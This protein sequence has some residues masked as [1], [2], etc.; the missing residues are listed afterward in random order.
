M[1]SNTLGLLAANSN[2][3]CIWCKCNK[4]L[5][6]DTNK[7][8]SMTNV[9]QGARSFDDMRK[10]LKEN[11]PDKKCGY[12]LM[13]LIT[14][15]VPWHHYL[16]DMLHLF[17]RISDKLLNNL[18]DDIVVHDCIISINSNNTSTY[19]SLKRLEEFIN[20]D[21]KIKF[22]FEINDKNKLEMRS[23]DGHQKHKIFSK[24]DIE[25]I[26][27]GY[28]KASTIDKIWKDF[29]SIYNSI[30]SKTVN[31]EQVKMETKEWLKL[32]CTVYQQSTI[33]PYMHA[34]VYHLHEFINLYKDI[35][36][37]TLEGS[38]KFNDLCTK[39]YF[40]GSDKKDDLYQMM[41]Q[42][43]RIELNNFCIPS[44]DNQTTD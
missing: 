28:S 14:E 4:N 31:N 7:I 5:F 11:K 35:D 25:F 8:W 44:D 38:E 6:Y 17:L 10:C 13:P 26:L 19:P 40:S 37:F 30:K 3:P 24:I 27:A 16:I 2:Y 39:Y 34:F 32:Y 33:T 41:A 23:I 42:R 9:D 12:N 20:N 43:N 36:I 15:K 21:C 29:Y 22:F 18:L 1:H